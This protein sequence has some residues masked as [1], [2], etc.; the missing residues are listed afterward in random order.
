[1]KKYLLAIISL[2]I[3]SASYAQITYTINHDGNVRNFNIHVPPNYNANY[4][5]P[6]VFNFHGYGSNAAQQEIYSLMGQVSDTGNFIVVYPNGLANAWNVGFVGNYSTTLPDDVGFTQAI[7]D[8]MIA[9][10]NID[11]NRVYSCGMSNGGYFTYRLA[12]EMSDKFAAFASVT[13]SMTDSMRTYCNPAEK[14]PMMQI[15]GTDDPL[16]AYNGGPNTMPIENMINFW[17]NLKSCS[18]PGDTTFLPNLEAQDSSAVQKIHY[19]CTIGYEFLFYKIINGG[20]T[21]PGAPI[22]ISLGPTNRDIKGSVE[23]WNFFN[24]YTKAGGVGIEPV[25]EIN[26]TVYPNPANNKLT[27]EADNYFTNAELYNL[28]GE[29]VVTEKLSGL[30]NNIDVSSLQTGLYI[31]K[32]S[33]EKLQKVIRFEKL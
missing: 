23:I 15:H 25:E 17:T 18:F 5:Y 16:V 19:D 3:V 4:A 7:L 9:I 13:G 10:Y 22:N 30:T 28:L 8:T 20:H 27:I 31:I 12:C 24:R 2:L 14:R 6:L 29:K 11:Q 33:N 21:W 1:M 26:V 32:L